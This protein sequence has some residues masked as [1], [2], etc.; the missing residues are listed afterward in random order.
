MKQ[1]AV[2]GASSFGKRILEELILLDCEIILIDKDPEVVDYFKN[3]VTAAYIADVINE[4]TVAKLVPPD[5]DAAV[6]DLGDKIEA[7]ILATQYLSKLG[8]AKIIVKAETDQHGEILSIVGADHVVFP[9]LEA[10]KRVSP[11]LVSDL[12]FNYLPISGGLV[13]AE[14]G[15]PDDLEGATLMETDIRRAKGINVVAFRKGGQGEY[16]F[17][18]P[19]YRLQK[20]D[21]L[22]IVGRDE[23]VSA[24]T[25]KELGDRRRGMAELFRRF[26][27]NGRR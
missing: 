9:N 24:F 19:E 1:Y 26:F 14:T 20:E 12:L 25:G 16:Q 10:A 15:V 27:S 5:I 13:M 7:S 11:L 8:V 18:V 21:V 3:D 22:L 23:D 6:V 2:I 17:F 4:E